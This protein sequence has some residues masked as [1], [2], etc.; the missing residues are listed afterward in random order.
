MPSLYDF[1]Q[2]DFNQ[3]EKPLDRKDSIQVALKEYD[4]LRKEIDARTDG[5]KT[6]AWPVI[7]LAGTTLAGAKIGVNPHLVFFLI[8]L[9][10]MTIFVLATNAAFDMAKARKALARVE[11]RIFVLSGETLLTHESCRVAEWEHGIGPLVIKQTA[12]TVIYWVVQVYVFI[13]LK[14]KLVAVLNPV[15][16]IVLVLVAGTLTTWHVNNIRGWYKL[17]NREF[18]PPLPLLAKVRINK[19][20]LIATVPVGRQVPIQK[21]DVPQE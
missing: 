21:L 13:A 8:P 1:Y 15:H 19:E 7:L 14:A 2:N 6:Y 11:N 16:I 5:T 20:V 18:N 17:R 4:G 12:G 3:N 9:V 10:G